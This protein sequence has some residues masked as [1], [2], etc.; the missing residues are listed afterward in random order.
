MYTKNVFLALLC[1]VSLF[2]PSKVYSQYEEL[3]T[4]PIEGTIYQ[5]NAQT[6][7]FAAGQI[8]V[9]NFTGGFLRIRLSKEVS[10]GNWQQISETPLS[11]SH[12]TSYSSTGVTGYFIDLGNHSKG[13]YRVELRANIGTLINL[14]LETNNF[15]IGDV[16]FIAG[17]SNAAGPVGTSVNDDHN[18]FFSTETPNKRARFLHSNKKG[19]PNNP[20]DYPLLKSLVTNTKV[21]TLP[22]W[23]N[24]FSEISM[25]SDNSLAARNAIY[26]SG[27]TSW[28]WSDFANK[29]ANAGTPVLLFNTAISNSPL[30][31][32]PSSTA[33]SWNTGN[34]DSYI[35]KRFRST[36][37]NFGHILGAKAVLWHQGERDVIEIGNPSVNPD[38]YWAS[39]KTNLLNLINDSKTA[40]GDTSLNWYVSQVSHLSGS[41]QWAAN[42]RQGVNW[43]SGCEATPFFYQ[44]TDK[45]WTSSELKSKQHEVY[46]FKPTDLIFEGI[47][48][49]NYN[50]CLRGPQQRTHFS[51]SN[52][53]AIAEAW[54]LK[55]Q[56]NSA[57][58]PATSVEKLVSVSKSGSNNFTLVAPSYSGASYYWVKNNGEIGNASGSSYS[59]TLS[60]ED[61]VVCYIKKS[62][63][64]I[65]TTNPFVASGSKILDAL[66]TVD[67][68][69]TLTAP[70]Q[71]TSDNIIWF[72]DSAP[73][74][75]SISQDNQDYYTYTAS[76]N[77]TGNY[78]SGNI[79]L[80][81][82]EG[83]ITKNTLIFQNSTANNDLA[84]TSLTPVSYSESWLTTNFN[85]TN[86]AGNDMY[87][88]GIQY[89]QGIGTSAQGSVVYN[90]PSGYTFFNGKVGRDDGSD[91]CACGPMNCSFQ[92]KLNGS[93]IWSSGIHSV[94]SA[95]E[96][97][98]VNVSGGG[99]LELI[100]NETGDGQ[101]GDW[102]DWV[103]VYLSGSGGGGGS[104]NVPEPTNYQASPSTVT[105]GSASS[106][107]ATC[108][109]GT[110]TW[111]TTPTQTGSP[112]TV[113][114]STTTNYTVKC[115]NGSQPSA[116]R[117]VTVTVT[118]SNNC[119]PL[120]NNLYMGVWTVTGDSFFARYFN[121]QYW[122]TQKVNVNGSQYDEFVVRASEM[123]TRGDFTTSY[124][125]D[126]NNSC[127]GMIYSQY[128]GLEGPNNANTPTFNTPPGY[129]LYQSNG[130]HYYSTYNNNSS[131]PITN[132]A[133]YTIKSTINNKYLTAIG[134]DFNEFQS[135]NSG[136]TKIWKFT[137][138]DNVNW[139]VTSGEG[140]GKFL[141][142]TDMYCGARIK[143]TTS[144]G[145][146]NQLWQF[147]MNGNDFRFYAS[148]GTTWD[149]EGAGSL[150]NLQMCGDNTQGF[151]TYRLFSL[152]SASC[153]SGV[154]MGNLEEARETEEEE[155]PFITVSPNPN[156][157]RFKV[158]INLEQE[159]L[160]TLNLLDILGRKH[161][162]HAFIG[163]AGLTVEDLNI[164]NISPGTYFI[165]AVTNGKTGST[166]VVIE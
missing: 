67:A 125:N 78:R 66:P 38:T 69:S 95:A 1:L 153:P 107:S 138:S 10:P 89:T 127:W 76:Q 3:V 13:W 45:K 135:G 130:T 148:N 47:L 119:A 150:N 120:S 102:A 96:D 99:T 109:Q 8:P 154:R 164:K 65:H 88:N 142:A 147:D 108:S 149:H 112:V 27:E 133:C 61:V 106:L 25:G 60:A 14:N 31:S 129:Y 26:P 145:Q 97:F 11:T 152:A 134:G 123:L 110:V 156:S 155:L 166:R 52:L 17:Q 39:Y 63:G 74:W 5:D 22:Y 41:S 91:N 44:Q 75:I 139:K 79:V 100:S 37:E 55:L 121:N 48:S 49:D 111:G 23:G 77:T 126:F 140:S 19:N 85:G 21:R 72:V 93:I 165:Q 20:E 132:G 70:V 82:S 98:S 94:N 9:D 12:Y 51:G 7:I 137:S 118:N 64:K 90:I 144:S 53:S 56:N 30:G 143:R 43:I 81:D 35:L 68:T 6:S 16:Y 122:L 34:T 115:V 146:A 87:I 161:F 36:L 59:T 84:L 29:I 101:W 131:G 116:N 33:E 80:K 32:T 151:Q 163:Q 86:I 18:P 114:P 57:S 159:E 141:Y 157:G 158:H 160:V 113:Y 15:G 83:T 58:V 71:V 117:T 46:S 128:G 103:N 2:L 40:I 28:Y 136:S 105:A 62:N 73:S 104:N 162:E 50:E 4:L 42:N 92:I 24:G 124:S 54:K